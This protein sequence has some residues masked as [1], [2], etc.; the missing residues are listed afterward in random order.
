VVLLPGPNISGSGANAATALLFA[1]PSNCRRLG[2]R[3][4]S[5]IRLFDLGVRTSGRASPSPNLQADTLS[6]VVC[7]G[8]V[9]AA[10]SI[11]IFKVSGVRRT[12]G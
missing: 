5:Y 2:E 10:V 1:R 3:R 9:L 11:G 12:F 8:R 6:D 7:I 4:G